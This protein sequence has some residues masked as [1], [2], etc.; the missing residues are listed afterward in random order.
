MVALSYP[1]PLE[2]LHK[3]TSDDWLARLPAYYQHSPILEQAAQLAFVVGN[4]AM[5]P[6]KLSGWQHGLTMAYSLVPLNV[7][8]ELLAAALLY[9]TWDYADLSLA[10]VEETANKS[11][12]HLLAGTAK[13]DAVSILHN[14]QHKN[15]TQIEN[16]R[17]MLLAM[18]EDLRVVLLKLAERLHALQCA[19]FLP[20]FAQQKLA[21]EVLSVYA[22]LANRLGLSTLKWQMEDFACRALYPDHY[23]E[24]AQQLGMK[25][26]EREALIE[27]TLALLRTYLT[28]AAINDCKITGRAKHI[29]SIH[30]KML[31]KNIRFEQLFDLHAVRIVVST[32]ED[33]YRVLDVVQQHFEMIPSEF[34]DY[35]SMPK[36]NGYRSIHTAVFGPDR[37]IIEIQIRTEAMHQESELGGA[38]HWRYKEGSANNQSYQEKIAW[39]REILS[40]QNEIEAKEKPEENVLADR[41]YVLTPRGDI[42]DLPK[43]ATPL[44]FAYAI[45]TNIGHR[46]RGAKIN[47]HIVS[48]HTPLNMGDQVELLTGKHLNPSRDWL[49]HHLGFLVTAR[50]RAKVAHWFRQ[51]D[52]GQHVIDGKSI[53]DQS[54]KRLNVHDVEHEALA[55]K[56]EYAHKEDLYAALGA[57]SLRPA[58]LM[59][60]LELWYKQPLQKTAVPE[61]SN[62]VLVDQK[63][64]AGSG[65]LVEG[66]ANWLTHIAQCCQPLPGDAIAGYISQKH[67]IAIHKISC[68]SF[69]ARQN[70]KPE[71][72]LSASWGNKQQAM[73]VV[74]IIEAEDRPHLAK[75]VTHLMTQEKLALLGIKHLTARENISAVEVYT[76]VR[77]LDEL[78]HVITRIQNIP[79]VRSVRR[80]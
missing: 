55:N 63:A 21:G 38:A 59:N 28:E 5:G 68:R 31:R 7:D 44:D 37:H 32:V 56:L 16:C 53:V 43:G 67:S 50:A 30:K 46:C 11:I 20:V 72:V 54:L 58:Q 34:V 35:I 80:K 62:K 14:T 78:N 52:Y 61:V 73:P 29:Y 39:L 3:M 42:I 27:K 41:V 18:V 47:G 75:E 9:P 71:R 74:L 26:V 2:T 13:M 79:Y 4:Q 12:A 77:D 51:Q 25:R 49:N 8:H 60:R 70:Q 10:D 40:W 1:F 57:N 36:A 23:Q 17:K 24:I 6:G 64:S 48:L 22:P 15:S 33:C 45:H 19:H 66:T 76:R 69:L 65:I